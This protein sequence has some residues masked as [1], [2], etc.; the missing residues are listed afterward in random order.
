MY[1]CMYV[2]R[3]YVY[4]HNPEGPYQEVSGDHKRLQ[5]PQYPVGATCAKEIAPL[6]HIWSCIDLIYAHMS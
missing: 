5:R 2:Y 3:I 6:V 4:M 1:V